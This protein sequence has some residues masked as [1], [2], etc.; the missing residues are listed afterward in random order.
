[1]ILLTCFMMQAQAQSKQDDV[2]PTGKNYWKGLKGEDSLKISRV[3]TA[4]LVLPGY[5]QAYNRQYWKIP[6]IWGGIGGL[7]YGGYAGNMKWMDTGENRYK[8][9]RAYCYAGAAL[10]YWASSLDGVVNY[11]SDKKII[12]A[13]MTIYS[14]ILPGLGQTHNGHYW[15]IPIIYGGLAFTTYMY[16]YNSAQYQRFREAYNALTDDDPDT[17]DEFNGQMN[18]SQL[19]SYRDNFRR[20]RDYAVVYTGLVYILNIIDANVFAHLSDFDVSDNLSLKISPALLNEH[21]YAY[22]PMKAPVVGMRLNIT[23]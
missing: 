2:S 21:K 5:S 22:Q 10:I 6:I 14:A 23:F 9:Q 4:S 11:Q 19:Q 17:V 18:A 8:N 12:P 16:N 1:M 7:I 13:R 15:K 20:Q 3:W